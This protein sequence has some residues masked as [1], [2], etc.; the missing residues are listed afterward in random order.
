L[1]LVLGGLVFEY[2]GNLADLLLKKIGLI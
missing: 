2:V 1:V